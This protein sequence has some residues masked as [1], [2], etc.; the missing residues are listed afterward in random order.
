VEHDEDL[1]DALFAPDSL[2]PD[3]FRETCQRRAFTPEQK[4][5][6]HLIRDC[7]HQARSPKCTHQRDARGWV[8][9]PGDAPM[10]FRFCCYA[11]GIEPDFLRPRMLLL[12]KEQGRDRTKLIRL[13]VLAA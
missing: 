10:S 13:S 6:I 1:L 3:Q 12:M 5:L 4:L 8:C 9:D 7:L 11:L 2:T